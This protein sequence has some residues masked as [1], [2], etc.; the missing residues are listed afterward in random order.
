MWSVSSSGLSRGA[1]Y[2]WRFVL[3]LG[4]IK[5]HGSF[6]EDFPSQFVA[7]PQ[8]VYAG[9]CTLFLTLQCKP[10]RGTKS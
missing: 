9:L 10:D 2:N 6:L 7:Y 4:H 8:K 5:G 1:F 3:W